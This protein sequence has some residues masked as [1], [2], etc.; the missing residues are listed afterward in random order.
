MSCYGRIEHRLQSYDV[1]L[2]NAVTYVDRPANEDRCCC[3]AQFCY[4]CGEQWKTCECAQWDETRLLA[5]ANLVLERRPLPVPHPEPAVA[6]DDEVEDGKLGGPVPQAAS[7]LARSAPALQRVLED[8][9]ERHECA[10]GEWRWIHGPRQCEESF[11]QLPQY[12]FE[13]RHCHL[14]A[15]NLGP[16]TGWVTFGPCLL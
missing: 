9:R 6:L 8:L 2:Q 10:H 11:H 7:A 5:R 14:Q 16:L 4:V 1:G 13:C 15:W 12:I 3:D